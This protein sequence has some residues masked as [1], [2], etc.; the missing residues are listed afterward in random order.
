LVLGFVFPQNNK[1]LLRTGLESATGW[2]TA[3]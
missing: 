2:L 3:L 1:K